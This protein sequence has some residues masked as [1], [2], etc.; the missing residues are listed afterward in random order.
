MKRTDHFTYTIR[1][2]HNDNVHGTH[3]SILC[4][5]STLKGVLS[6]FTKLCAL[7][8]HHRSFKDNARIQL[9]SPEGTTDIAI[10]N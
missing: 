3:Q 10:I 2:W 9:V 8:E 1:A 5:A 7:P 4:S 6:Q